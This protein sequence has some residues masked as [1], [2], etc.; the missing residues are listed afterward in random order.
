[1]R[2][3]KSISNLGSKNCYYISNADILKIMLSAQKKNS[4][5]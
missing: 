5:A 1:M 2:E 4:R 3:N